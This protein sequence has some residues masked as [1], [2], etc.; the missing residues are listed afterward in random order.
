MRAINGWTVCKARLIGLQAEVQ[1]VKHAQA[2][3]LQGGHQDADL[4]SWIL[5]M[6]R[7]RKLEYM[8]PL[9]PDPAGLLLGYSTPPNSSNVPSGFKALTYEAHPQRS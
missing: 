3:V 7:Y 6:V 9:W 8:E 1:Q 4:L 5:S 2:E